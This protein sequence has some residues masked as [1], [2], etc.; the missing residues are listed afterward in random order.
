MTRLEPLSLVIRLE[1][2]HAMK[3][4]TSLMLGLS[5]ALG[6]FAAFAQDTSGSTEKKTVK[7]KKNRRKTVKKETTKTEDKQN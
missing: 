3:K 1:E 6:S 2:E 4:L 7:E 5:M